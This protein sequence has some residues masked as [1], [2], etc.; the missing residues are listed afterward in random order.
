MGSSCQFW[1]VLHGNSISNQISS[2]TVSD[3]VNL[4]R[5][6][7]ITN[8][9]RFYSIHC[10]G[11]IVKLFVYSHVGNQA[12]F[13][14]ENHEVLTAELNAESSVEFFASFHQTTA[15]YIDDNRTGGNK[16]GGTVDIHC[17]CRT[18]VV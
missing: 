3:H 1:R 2:G 12:I 10:P 8:D 17:V 11:N 9:K 7:L 15:V 4:V 18:A 14:A 6:T 16:T 13:N 5:I